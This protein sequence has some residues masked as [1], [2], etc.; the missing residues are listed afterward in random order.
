MESWHRRL[1][2]VQSSRAPISSDVQMWSAIPTATG[3][4]GYGLSRLLWGRAQL[5]YIVQGHRGLA[6]LGLLGEPVGQPDGPPRGHPHREVLPLGDALMLR[7]GLMP[8]TRVT[9]F[10]RSQS[11]P[12]FNSTS[13]LGRPVS[14]SSWRRSLIHESPPRLND[15]P[16]PTDRVRASGS[17]LRMADLRPVLLRDRR[18]RFPVV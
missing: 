15:P 5:T 8:V 10:S 6:V 13:S 18:S 2:A 17:L 3:I 7:A 12:S 11:P 16:R 14:S 1:P 9:G 4:R